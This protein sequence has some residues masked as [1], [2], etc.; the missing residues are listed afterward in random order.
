MIVRSGA[1]LPRLSGCSPGLTPGTDE[2]D[3]G[4]EDSV[5]LSRV[6]RTVAEA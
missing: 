6:R 1:E 2:L 5:H 3:T 4:H